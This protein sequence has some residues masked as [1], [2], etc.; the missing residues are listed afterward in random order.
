MSPRVVRV[1][2]DFFTSLDS[3]LPHVRGPAGEPTAAEFAASELLEIVD[4]FARHWD[5]LPMPIAGRADYRDLILTTRL[6][7][8]VVV[9]GQVSP[10]DGGIEL[11]DIELDLTGLLP[12]EEDADSDD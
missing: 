7:P 11:I 6:V 9:R 3:Q 5:Q 4:A 12:A 8:H 1:S 2:P 10:A